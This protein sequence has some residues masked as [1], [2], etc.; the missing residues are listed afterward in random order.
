[1][2]ADV[3]V[4]GLGAGGH[5]KVVIDIL[6]RAGGYRI[7]GLL[8]RD[9]A[10]WGTS[11]LGLPVLGGDEL[12]PELVGQTRFAFLGVGSIGDNRLRGRLFE[13]AMNLGFEFVKAVHPSAAVGVGATLSAGVA[14][15]AAA[16]IGPCAQLAQNVIVNSGAVVEHD[17]RLGP[18]VHIAPRA[19]LSGNVQVEEYAHV[20]AGATVIQGIHIGRRAIVGAGAV[21]VR[22]VPDD[23]LVVGVPARIV[24]KRAL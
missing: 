8:D 11:V 16:V 14:V 9:Q 23:V 3:S 12:L 6:L 5:A 18:H 15:M 1:M 13:Q 20:G 22:D 24:T 7:L 4:V 10:L 19:C 21:V 17:C 2:S